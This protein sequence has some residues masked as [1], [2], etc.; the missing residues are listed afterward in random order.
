MADKALRIG[1]IV[2]LA[3]ITFFPELG[4]EFFIAHAAL[5]FRNGV[6]NTPPAAVI[7][8]TCGLVIV[9]IVGYVIDHVWIAGGLT[10]AG[11]RQRHENGQ[12]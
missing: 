6:R 7:I 3:P 9:V 12:Y 11:D 5:L 2:L 1:P 10:T 4:G 8:D